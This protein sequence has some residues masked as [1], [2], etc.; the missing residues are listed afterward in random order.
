MT[1]EQFQEQER[2]RQAEENTI[3]DPNV[4]AMLDRQ[5]GGEKAVVSPSNIVG[6]QREAHEETPPNDNSA[7]ILSRL[8]AACDRKAAQHELLEQARE[9]S[10]LMGE[11]LTKEEFM[12][13]LNQN[14]DVIEG[15]APRANSTPTREEID[16][17]NSRLGTPTEQDLQ[18]LQ[19][20]LTLQEQLAAEEAK[21]DDDADEL[22]PEDGQPDSLMMTEEE[23]EGMEDEE[24]AS[25]KA[26]AVRDRTIS[27]TSVC[28][29]KSDDQLSYEEATKIFETMDETYYGEDID[30]NKELEALDHNT[31]MS[32]D[33][34]LIRKR[35]KKLSSLIKEK[36]KPKT[37]AFDIS[38][39]SIS[40]RPAAAQIKVPKS[41]KMDIADWVLMSSKRPI[42]MR[43]FS[44]SDIERL[45]N[46]GKGR[47]KL[48]RALDVWT[49]IYKHIVDPYKP[50]S[51]EAWA[52]CTS[53][54]DIDHIYMAIYRANFGGQNYI[55][56]TCDAC[57]EVFL[58]DD[59]D[60]MEM[61]KF[62]DEEARRTFDS[63]IGTQH[64]KLSRLY[65]TEVIPVSDDYAFV[66]REP[67]IYNIIF[68]SAILD[69]EFVDK[70]GDMVS[71]CSYID[72]IYYI[73]KEEKIL[74]PVKTN[75]YRNKM[76]KTVQARIIKYSQ[77]MSTLTSDQYNTILAY[78]QNINKGG[79]SL[80]YQLPEVNCPKCKETIK[81][82]PADAQQLV[83]TRHQLAAL[84]TS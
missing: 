48:N 77:I 71:F 37:E 26:P 21:L 3:I 54:L 75:V 46:G 25:G 66:F 23:Y 13:V 63:I 18:A 82:R 67:S 53:F 51:V 44:G 29:P 62:E 27:S 74:Q 34:E 33:D 69:E 68:E 19:D 20:H 12:D 72:N 40:Q 17:A 2:R 24:D 15:K 76:Q 28:P 22:V 45:A 1:L 41:S 8:D 59:M 81:A 42:Y 83:F 7:N 79:E 5:S 61:C 70:F 80:S 58:T 16:Y 10:A 64:S 39:F 4:Q 30:Y 78:M 11:E 6:I 65:S 50:D 52:K 31:G 43:K 32:A 49:L 73:N 14:K 55:P 35:N 60:I 56:Y 36:V 47:T 57:N 84:A 38:S 9:E